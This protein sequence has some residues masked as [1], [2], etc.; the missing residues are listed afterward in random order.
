[1][2][3]YEYVSFQW[4]LSDKQLNELGSNGW[5]LISHTAVSS[6]SNFGQYYVFMREIKEIQV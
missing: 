6:D 1:M 4:K 3:K 2:Q 5:K